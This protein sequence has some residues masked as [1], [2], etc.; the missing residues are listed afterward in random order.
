MPEPVEIPTIR[1]GDRV[2]F[3]QYTYTSAY[4]LKRWGRNIASASWLELAAA[5]AYEAEGGK[6][7]SAGFERPTDFA[8]LIDLN[9]APDLT[10]P[11]C[12]A[13]KK[14]YP[15]LEFSLPVP[16]TEIATSQTS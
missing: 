13:L 14:A 16:A 11:T 1:I 4:Q 5:M 7:R 15:D 3:L 6:L 2:F 12:E 10:G 9:N 8:D